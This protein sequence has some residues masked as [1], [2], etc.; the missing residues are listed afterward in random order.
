M[1]AATPVGRLLDRRAVRQAEREAARPP[2]LPRP[3]GRTILI[4]ARSAT[5]I[6]SR[7]SSC[8][9]LVGASGRRRLERSDGPLPARPI[10][11]RDLADQ[12]RARPTPRWSSASKETGGANLVQGFANLL[13]DVGSGKGIV[14]RRTDPDAFDKGKTIAATPGEVVFENELFQLIQYDSGDRQG[15]GRAAALRAAAGEPLLHDRPRAAVEPGQMA[16]RRGPH[17]VRHHLGQSRRRSISDKDVADYVLDGHRRGDRAGSQAHRRSARPV[18]LLPR[19]DAGRDRARL[20][21]GQGP[22]ERGQFARP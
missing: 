11:E 5:P 4:T 16:G 21:R 9:T 3:N 6:C 22:R 13:E 14:Q 19:R 15:R 20:A 1:D 17:R 10:S 7:R 2:L 18:L 8:A 12:F